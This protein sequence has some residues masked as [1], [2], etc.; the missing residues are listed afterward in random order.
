[1]RA[2]FA[3]STASRGTL[4]SGISNQLTASAMSSVMIRRL[5]SAAGGT[6][7]KMGGNGSVSMDDG[8]LAVVA[9]ALIDVFVSV[10]PGRLL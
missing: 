4:I 7:S 9:G 3:C 6:L 2:I 10:V 1:M 8:K 5:D